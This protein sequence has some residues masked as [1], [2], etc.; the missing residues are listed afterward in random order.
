MGISAL[1]NGYITSSDNAAQSTSAIVANKENIVISN[2]PD[3]LINP[4]S[5]FIFIDKEASSKGVLS[6]AD[7]IN[8]LVAIDSVHVSIYI[9]LS[10]WCN[11]I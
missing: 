11:Y 8:R 10:I 5:E 9:F 1:W 4:P 3:N 2:P 7:L 6:E